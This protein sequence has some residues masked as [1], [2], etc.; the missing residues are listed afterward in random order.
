M[1]DHN[2]DKDKLTP[3]IKKILK[4]IAEKEGVKVIPGKLA[5]IEQHT[6]GVVTEFCFKFEQKDNTVVRHFVIK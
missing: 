1:I 2:V 4:V 3:E 5:D 6:D